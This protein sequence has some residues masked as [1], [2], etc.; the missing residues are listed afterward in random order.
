MIWTQS[1]MRERVSIA[2][3]TYNISGR[4]L[5]GSVIELRTNRTGGMPGLHMFYV[6][7]YDPATGRENVQEF[8]DKK[9]A[10]AEYNAMCKRAIFG[11]LK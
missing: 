6:C 3:D 4:F 2:G 8:R 10:K 11:E 5:N 7:V 1:T 9:T